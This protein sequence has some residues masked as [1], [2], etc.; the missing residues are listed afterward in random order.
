VSLRS[1]R[2]IRWNAET[3]TTEGDAEAGRLL[4]REYRAPWTL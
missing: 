2:K 4:T 1:G 3:E